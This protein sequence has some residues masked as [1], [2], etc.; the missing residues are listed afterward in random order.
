MKK[1]L[2][3]SLLLF[4]SLTLIAKEENS[5]KD[6][7][8]KGVQWQRQGKFEKALEVYWQIEKN[9]IRSDNLFYNMGNCYYRLNQ[10]GAARAYYEKTLKIN[11]L[12]Y[13]AEANLKLTLKKIM[14]FNSQET[15]NGRNPFKILTRYQWLALT[16]V[17]VMIFSI[18]FISFKFS[19]ILFLRK[20][21]LTTLFIMGLSIMISTAGYF[22]FWFAPKEAIVIKDLEANESP[23]ED[24]HLLKKLNAGDKIYIVEKL[25]KWTKVK[26]G[27]NVFWVKSSGIIEI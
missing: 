15:N 3:I 18:C 12:H 23:L 19:S 22:S 6:L 11:P 27:K 21:M 10:W 4:I 1:Q 2:F 14:P 13:D 24:G 9:K 25:D 8:S 20:I 5:N 26:Q 7:F 17:L 16:T